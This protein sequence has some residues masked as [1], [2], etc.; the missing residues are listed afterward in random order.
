MGDCTRVCENGCISIKNGISVIDPTNCTGCGKCVKACPNDLIVLVPESKRYIVRCSSL[1]T[2]KDTRGI[3]KN[4]CIACGICVKKCP[5]GAVSIDNNHA[6][7][8][9]KACTGCGACAK[10]CPVKCITGLPLN[11]AESCEEIQQ[12]GVKK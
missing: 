8:D 10:A 12:N 11:T 5:V 6:I 1:D 7:I 9:M 4:G 2:G 3:C